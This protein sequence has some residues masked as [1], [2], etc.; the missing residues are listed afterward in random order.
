MRTHQRAENHAGPTP[1]ALP[2]LRRDNPAAAQGG[3]TTLHY[4]VGAG[5][6]FSRISVHDDHGAGFDDA[7]Q[8]ARHVKGT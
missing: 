7:V 4:T 6:D 5:H 2:A 8:Q 3:P 1:I